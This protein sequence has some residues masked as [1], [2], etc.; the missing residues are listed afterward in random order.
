M[1]TIYFSSVFSMFYEICNGI[2]MICYINRF[3]KILK[4]TKISDDYCRVRIEPYEDSPS[5][6]YINASYI[7]KPHY[8]AASAANASADA[9]DT[10]NL[11][12]GEKFDDH[13]P[14][15]HMKTINA[16][17][18][19]GEKSNVNLGYTHMEVSSPRRI[20]N[21]SQSLTSGH[22]SPS[23]VTSVP[24]VPTPQG[25]GSDHGF[26]TD[27]TGFSEIPDVDTRG[28]KAYITAQN[29]LPATVN[30]FWRMVWQEGCTSIIMLTDLFLYIGVSVI[31]INYMYLLPY[32]SFF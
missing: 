10:S 7:Y 13:I 12:S 27:S 24:S 28:P 11:E 4:Y 20:S 3:C 23:T 19:I 6:A 22:C 5:T 1:P 16:A 2:G 25:S 8:D 14:L 30:D 15:A 32:A 9:P 29:P 31:A 21:D 18:K 17:T 26:E